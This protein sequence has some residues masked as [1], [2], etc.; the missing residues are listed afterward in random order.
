VTITKVIGLSVLRE[1]SA[2]LT[3]AVEQRMVSVLAAFPWL[4][5]RTID[6]PARA[7]VVVWGHGTYDDHLHTEPG[8]VTW[9]LSNANASPDWRRVVEAYQREPATVSR[10]VGLEG[11]FLL[12][13]ISER[14]VEI[15]NDW[16]GASKLYTWATD[17]SHGVSTLEPIAVAAAAISE[18]DISSRSLY[19]LMRFGTFMG[20]STLYESI[21]L[22][23]PE[24]YGTLT[25]AGLSATRIGAIRVS[26]SRWAAGWD[27]VIDEWMALLDEAFT[28][29]LRPSPRSTLMLS[30]GIDSRLI[31][32][33]GTRNRHPFE[34]VS[35]GNRKWQDG[36]VAAK[37]AKALDLPLT[38]Y[39]I[40]PDYLTRY[41][42][43]W[44]EWFGASMAVHGMYQM[45]ALVG[46][47]R[48]GRV[49]PITTGF[50]GDPLEGMQT[51]ELMRR[52]PTESGTLS[53]RLA[54]KFSAWSDADI[55]RLLPDLDIQKAREGIEQELQDQYASFEGA[56]FQ[57]IWLLFQWNRVFQFSSYQPTMYEYYTGVITP[58][59]HTKLANFTLSLP[60]YALEGR[61]TILEL[62]RK[63]FPDM[64]RLPGTYD[65][66]SQAFEFIPARYGIPLLL[67]KKYLAKAAVGYAAPA[68]LRRGPLREFSPAQNAF[69]RDA[70]RADGIKALYPLDRTSATGTWRFDGPEV[71]RQVQSVLGD[72]AMLASVKLWPIQA[73]LHRLAVRG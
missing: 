17:A 5:V 36:V 14:A 33:T 28:E 48:D 4:T 3:R 9:V 23:A 27:D 47:R 32:A 16:T 64:A 39:P 55:A 50:T 18:S 20:T 60:R 57:R 54:R 10:S 46:L 6:A 52:V 69:A 8:G 26:D 62:I 2:D 45:P 1:A 35:Y 65:H 56:E 34:A 53:E 68:F 58:F 40:D 71:Q 7:H 13:R 66:P 63:H 19:A 12:V 49:A 70:L 43:G 67:T 51:R 11:I 31:A 61:R 73:L 22:L 24:S 29:L 42:R 21:R 25:A 41:T 44:C 37:V 15:W 30:G 38:F 72:E 59:V